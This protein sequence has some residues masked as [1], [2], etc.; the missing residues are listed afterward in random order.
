M[1]NQHEIR[2]EIETVLPTADGM[3]DHQF[4]EDEMPDEEDEEDDNDGSDNSD[5]DADAPPNDSDSF[6]RPPYADTCD[7]VLSPSKSDAKDSSPPATTPAAEIVVVS[8]KQPLA[9]KDAA[10]CANTPNNKAT[11]TAAEH[12]VSFSGSSSS[13]KCVVASDGS[14]RKEDTSVEP[15]AQQAKRRRTDYKPAEATETCGKK[16]FTSPVEILALISPA[17]HCMLS[18]NHNDHRWCSKYQPGIDCA[19]WVGD[20]KKPNYSRIFDRASKE[21]WQGALKVVHS[22]V[23]TKWNLHREALPLQIDPQEPGVISEDILEQLS[24]T[25]AR[26]PPKK[27]YTR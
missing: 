18:L 21:S 7:V 15:L 19:A 12:E 11:P 20:L 10:K 17:P 5:P 16:I 27:R 9:S 25:V 22:R 24:S 2:Q 6:S 3:N 1:L 23:W 4:E 14:D 8:S 13:A 26:L